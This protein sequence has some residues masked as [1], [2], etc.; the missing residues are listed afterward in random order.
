MDFEVMCGIYNHVLNT[1]DE[2]HP[3]TSRLT[4][5]QKEIV[6]RITKNLIKPTRILVEIKSMN[7]AI[8]TTLKKIY[9]V[10]TLGVGQGSKI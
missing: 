7:S 10:H 5:E 4:L 9:N 6:V 3:F 2:D 1:F 8:H